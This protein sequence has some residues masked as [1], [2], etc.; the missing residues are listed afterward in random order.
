VSVTLT[1]GL[2]ARRAVLDNGAVVL[3]QANPASPVV[4]IQATFAAGSVD[5]PERL[6]G[7]AYLV[8]RTIDRGTADRPASAIAEQL[9]DRGV[10]LWISAARHTFSIACVCLI[11]DFEAMTALIADVA[12]TPVFPVEEV[13][14]RRLQAITSLREEQ[15]DPS[16][17]AVDLLHEEL[18]GVRHPYGRP[19]K[20]TL[21]GL[22]NAGRQDLVDYHAAY[23]VPSALRIA[24][25]GDVSTDRAIDQV[26]RAFGDWRGRS[27]PAAPVPPPPPRHA[28]SI[29]RHEMPGKVQTDIAYGFTTIR[30]LDPRY[31]AF[32]MMNNVLGQF[33][34]GGRLA[35]NIRERQGMA[36]YTYSTL[37]A[38]VGEGP[39]VIRAG[40][41][42]ANVD[43]TIEAIDAEV[44]ALGT[45]GPAPDEVE[46]TRVSL[47]GSIPRMLETNEA[48]ADFL[49]QAELFDLGLDFDRRLPD[50]LRAVTLDD[51]RE[52]AR[53]VLRP[54]RA[55]I[56]VAG[57]PE[58]P[59]A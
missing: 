48:I 14:K 28:R 51:V 47:I 19:V 52:A 12:R 54:D 33:G 55:A 37:E 23:L 7:V 42:P 20:G 3:A 49:V 27:A 5:D 36:Y 31:Y 24:V 25:A 46:D 2:S 29:R 45:L 9:D 6:P 32:W 57:P 30:R 56:V 15:D 8:R 11:E 16:T 34:L 1:R 21:G 50:I 10:S 17:V 38:G 41:D 40:V 18:Y 39:L 58:S 43:R 26:A 4:A 59:A 22:E 13:D 35:D 53:E 44:R